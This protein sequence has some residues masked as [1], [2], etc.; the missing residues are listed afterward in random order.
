MIRLAV[1]LLLFPAPLV[2]QRSWC[3]NAPNGATIRGRIED[4]DHAPIQSGLAVLR[5]LKCEALADRQ[6]NFVLT[7]VPAGRHDLIGAFIGYYRRDTTVVVG[8]RDTL[9]IVFRLIRAGDVLRHNCLD[10]PVCPQVPADSSLALAAFQT[11]TWFARG[12]PDFASRR[13]CVE[14]RDSANRVL[15]FALPPGVFAATMCRTDPTGK[16]VTRSSGQPA[17]EFSIVL[18]SVA[19]DQAK[20][21]LRARAEWRAGQAHGCVFQLSPEGWRASECSTGDIEP[22]HW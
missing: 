9:T 1:L 22:L 17:V 12:L 6:G 2:A 5:K 10:W 15:A 13:Q 14:V 18:W 20:V 16:S 3:S 4:F 7:G 11:L 21:S 19:T 8:E